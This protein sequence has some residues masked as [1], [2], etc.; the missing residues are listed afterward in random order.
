VTTRK[1]SPSSL[2]E[3]AASLFRKAVRGATPLGSAPR[4][5]LEPKKP[6]PIP[7][8]SLLD[9]HAALVESASGPLSWEQ[10]IETGEELSYLREGLGRE[11]LLKLRR[12]HW[13]TQDMIDLHG[14]NRAQAQAQLSEFL[15]ICLKRQL[16]CVR[17]VHGKGLG[18]PRREPVLKGK[19]RLWLAQREE[20]LALCQAPQTQGGS[21]ALLV[22]LEA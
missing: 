13:V 22:L 3:E 7:V 1:G 8:Q 11:V 18:S 6:P 20:V 21:G 17:V 10:S 15:A 9:N 19:V 2:P 16:R 12:G 5:R 4:A 14:M